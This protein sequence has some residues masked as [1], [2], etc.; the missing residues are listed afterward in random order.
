MLEVILSMFY[1]QMFIGFVCG[2]GIA[3]CLTYLNKENNMK[4]NV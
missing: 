1:G 3:L 2:A 4:K